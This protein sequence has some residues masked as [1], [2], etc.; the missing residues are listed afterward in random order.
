MISTIFGLSSLEETPV[1]ARTVDFE[2][3]SLITTFV[4][5]DPDLNYHDDWYR[6]WSD[7]LDFGNFE[8]NLIPN[9]IYEIK[10]KL[11]IIVL[12][13]YDGCQNPVKIFIFNEAWLSSIS[14]GELDHSRSTVDLEVE[15]KFKS[16]SEI[17]RVRIEKVLV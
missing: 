3:R 4:D 12:K 10:P 8:I 11:G 17:D 9:L 13:R 7:L 16:Y 15:W 6:L 14:F 1:L 5:C 2:N